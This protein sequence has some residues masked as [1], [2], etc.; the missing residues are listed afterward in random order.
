MSNSFITP[1]AI[2][3]EA[4]VRLASSRVFAGLVHTDYSS[5]FQKKGDTVT[6]RKPA[7]FTAD[8][9]SSSINPQAVNEGSVD[10]KLDTIAD[11]SVDVTS[12]E[13]TLDIEDFGVQILD[14]AV[15]AIQEKIDQKIA[16]LYKDVP[17]YVGTSGTTPDGLDDLANAILVLNKN[18]VPSSMRRLVIDPNAHAKLI[19]LSAVV[20]AEKSGSTEALREAS[21]GRLL[22]MDT[23]MSQSIKTHVA[24]TAVQAATPLVNAQ[25]EAG[26]TEI[27]IKGLT[28]ATDTIVKGDIFTIDG[29][30]YVATANAT[31]SSN[32]VPVKVYPEVPARI[33][34]NAA[35]TF[36]DKTALGHVANL[37]FHRN[38]FAFVNRPL[39]LP[40]GYTEEQ[41][42]VANAQLPNG[43]GLSI[44]VVLGYNMTTKKNTVSLDCLFGVKTLYPEL[45]V[46]L[47]G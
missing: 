2:A 34:A 21:L 24:G 46:R 39:A 22:G 45:A 6:V 26:A 18:K 5:E 42:Y 10:V 17:Y 15:L 16:E 23:F 28:G 35:V 47:L 4:L 27:Q 19:Q 20:N 9:F 40:V 36:P 12:K 13:L 25:V 38:A 30:Q 14:G 3:R 7:V 31:G 8:E 11:V 29:Q 33:L 44:R 32:I 41:A 37:A 43:G 1:K